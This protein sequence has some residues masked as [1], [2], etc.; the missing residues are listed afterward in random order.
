M[1][2][3]R[4]ARKSPLHSP[5]PPSNTWGYLIRIWCAVG[6]TAATRG[7]RGRP[8][9]PGRGSRSTGNG[10]GV[11]TNRERIPRPGGTEPPS[12]PGRRGGGGEE[13]ELRREEGGSEGGR[14][15]SRSVGRPSTFTDASQDDV[16]CGGCRAAVG[17]RGCT[18]HHGRRESREATA[19]ADP[20]LRITVA[21]LRGRPGNN[22]GERSEE[23]C[24]PWDQKSLGI[25]GPLDDVSLQQLQQR[26]ITVG[27]VQPGLAAAHAK[28]PTHMLRL[29]NHALRSHRPN[30]HSK[31]PSLLLRAIKLWYVVPHCYSRRT[32]T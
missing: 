20:G 8:R 12:A 19:Q 16:T 4:D 30:R 6:G 9:G 21:G 22:W 10:R 7:R 32:A 3:R 11:A 31:T 28:I 15:A 1:S 29:Q 13:S 17:K 18:A 5:A 2:R 27:K 25:S 24:Y 23:L 14:S 26:F